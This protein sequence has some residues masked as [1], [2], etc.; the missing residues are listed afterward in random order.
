M[1]NGD[2]FFFIC[3]GAKYSILAIQTKPLPPSLSIAEQQKYWGSEPS[4]KY[5]ALHKV[6]YLKQLVINI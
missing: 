4:S 3:G 2:W 1:I 6:A 5:K